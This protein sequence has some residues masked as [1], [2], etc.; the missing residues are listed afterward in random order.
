MAYK[1]IISDEVSQAI[2][3]IHDYI[4]TVLLSSQSAK[5]TVGKILDG[6]KS[7]EVF[8]E[9]GFD[10]DEKIGIKINSKYPT[11][12]KIIG[13]YVLLYFIDQKQNTVFL[14]HLFHIKSDYV[15]LLQN[16]NKRSS[17]D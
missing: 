17:T 8:P 13:Q 9:A 11:R 2:D 16:G 6:L 12:G 5:N 15:T 14:S 4:T 1:V 7:L 10:A 3:S